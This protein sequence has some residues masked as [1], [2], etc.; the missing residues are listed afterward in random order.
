VEERTSGSRLTNADAARAQADETTAWRLESSF[1]DPLLSSG[2]RLIERNLIMRTLNKGASQGATP[3]IQSVETQA[4]LG[5]VDYLLELLMA[6]GNDSPIGCRFRI[7]IKDVNTGE[8]VGLMSTRAMPEVGRT[9]R[10]VATQGGF[11]HE[12]TTEVPSLED[13]AHCLAE[14]TM[15]QLA[16]GWELRSTRPREI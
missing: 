7:T 9:S 16:R 8:I 11:K 1:Y 2:V 12:T 3:D 14:D 15:F 10:F 6:S 13:F 4:L 5:K